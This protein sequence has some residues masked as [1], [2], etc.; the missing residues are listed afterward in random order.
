MAG[1]RDFKYFVDTG[2]ISVTREGDVRFTLVVRSPSG[3]DNVSYEGFRCPRRERRMYAVGRTDGT[4]STLPE[5][6]SRW[7]RTPTKSTNHHLAVLYDDF[8]CPTG[9]PIKDAAEGV[10]AMRRGGNPRAAA[11]IT[12]P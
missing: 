12:Q 7:D 4:W 1:R 6:S 2:S 5:S 8:L 3:V 9:I 11:E 10:L